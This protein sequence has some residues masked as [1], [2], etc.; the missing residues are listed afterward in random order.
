MSACDWSVWFVILNWSLCLFY[1]VKAATQ[2]SSSPCASILSQRCVAAAN[3]AMFIQDLEN[4]VMVHWLTPGVENPLVWHQCHCFSTVTGIG[5]CLTQTAQTEAHR[6]TDVSKTNSQECLWDHSLG[7]K[8]VLELRDSPSNWLGKWKNQEMG[9]RGYWDIHWSM[10]EVF[11][12]SEASKLQ[13]NIFTIEDIKHSGL[14][15]FLLKTQ[16][17]ELLTGLSFKCKSR[18]SYKPQRPK[19]PFILSFH[20]SHASSEALWQ[21]VLFFFGVK[22]LDNCWTR[23]PKSPP[24]DEL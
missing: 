18:L 3:F 5:W 6:P 24:Q 14:I 23:Q 20:F 17:S 10:G 1:F 13:H 8:I 12:A 2:L 21:S 11:S 19:P 22:C 15:A 4:T 16:N 7:S 9:Q